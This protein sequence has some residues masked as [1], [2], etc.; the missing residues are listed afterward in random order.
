MRG[1]KPR[2]R[3]VRDE[4]ASA[5]NGKVIRLS[6]TPRITVQAEMLQR[7]GI[8][9]GAGDGDAQPGYS[10]YT[11]LKA[12]TL[13]LCDE[14]DIRSLIITSPTPGTGKTV[15]AV[16]LGIQI[17]RQTNRTALLL[18]LNFRRPA[19]HRYFHQQPGCGIADCLRG[20]VAFADIL[21]SPV[22]RLSVAPSGHSDGDRSE[23]ITSAMMADLLDET[24][25]RY[26]ERLVILD[27]PSVLESDDVLALSANADAN[28][29]VLEAG[30]SNRG[31]VQ[32]ALECLSGTRTLGLV[33][34]RVD[35]R[36]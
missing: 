20:S 27:M 4:R 22:D 12:R 7:R 25:S 3:G 35:A 21:F 26:K 24:V 19:L 2:L 36:I 32:Q 1:Q 34:N 28:L 16:N 29:L 11:A 17:A 23:L 14:H 5:E 31:E 6:V 18:D 10:S 30:T 8:L 9:L 33:L 13:N 15:M